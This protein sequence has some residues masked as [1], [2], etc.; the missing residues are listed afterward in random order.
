MG[1]V[2]VSGMAGW[3]GGVQVQEEL[4]QLHAACTR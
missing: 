1:L 2:N 4:Q 3:G